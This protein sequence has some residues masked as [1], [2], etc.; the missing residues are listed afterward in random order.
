MKFTELQPAEYETFVQ[1]HQLGNFL[2][3]TA[4][5]KRREVSGWRMHLVGVKNERDQIVAAAQIGSRRVMRSYRDFECLQGP[6]L[7]YDDTSLVEYFFAELKVYLKKEKALQLTFNPPLLRNHR[8]A[9]A[10]IIAGSYDGEKYLSLL[11][12]QGARHISNNQ[13]DADPLLLR[14]YFAKDLSPYHTEADLLDG[15]D[16][17]TRWSVRKTQKLGIQVT[18]CKPTQLDTFYEL[19]QHTAAR[20]QFDARDKQYYLDLARLFGPQHIQFCLAE[21]PLDTYRHNLEQ[22]KAHE[23]EEL[24]TT[25]QQLKSQPGDKKLTTKSRVHREAIAQYDAKLAGIA[26]LGKP[27]TTLTLAGAIFIQYGDELVYFMSGSYDQ[28]SS[29]GAPYALQWHA[30]RYA[31]KHGIKRYNFYGTKGEFSGHPD[32]QGVYKFKKGFG[33]VVEEQIG[34]FVLPIHPLPGLIRRSLASLRRLA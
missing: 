1:Q 21:L 32:Q 29:F 20:R 7:D 18:V 8:D 14:W 10:E 13:V 25:E 9:S 17:Q 3:S 31:L 16:Q 11:R 19:M 24:H 5:G 27:G 26:K 4:I 22:L 12:S 30:L 6:I 33:G 28:Y 2:Q 23:V 34:Y 15:V